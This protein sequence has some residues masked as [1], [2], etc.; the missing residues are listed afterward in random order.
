MA[1]RSV[2]PLDHDTRRNVECAGRAR[3]FYP[4]TGIAVAVK[5]LIAA[6]GHRHRNAGSRRTDPSGKKYHLQSGVSLGID[7]YESFSTGT[8]AS[9]RP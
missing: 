7:T 9:D 3:Q 1:T 6:L 2:L 8:L 5:Y 4:S